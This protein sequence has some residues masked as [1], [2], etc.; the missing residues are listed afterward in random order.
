MT[1]YAPDF[2]MLLISATSGVIGT[3][4]EHLG[5]SMALN[6]PVYV[7]V[8]KIDACTNKALRQTLSTLEFLLKS[9]GC[10][11]IPLLVETEDDAVL[12]AQQ[13]F[14]FKICPIF[15]ISCVDGTNLNLLK[16]FLN[17]LPPLMN[18]KEEEFKM[19]E[20]TEFRVKFISLNLDFFRTYQ[21]FIIRWMKYILKRNLVIFYQDF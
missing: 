14:D 3:T 21:L 12:A 5:F 17:I 4:R 8:N 1:G 20:H 9:P 15:T 19:Q 16:K 6:V 11:K 7:V 10:N 18:K 2:N 13:F